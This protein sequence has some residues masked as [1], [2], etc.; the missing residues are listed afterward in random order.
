MCFQEIGG[1]AGGR[2]SCLPACIS[3]CLL[4]CLRLASTCSLACLIGGD[5]F[6]YL[7]RT[8]CTRF[9]IS[10]NEQAHTNMLQTSIVIEME[11]NGV[12]QIMVFRR[13]RRGN[14]QVVAFGQSR[15]QNLKLQGRR[16]SRSIGL[17]ICCFL[18]QPLCLG[19][20]QTS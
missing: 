19:K 15:K 1:W 14:P 3:A 13:V 18:L 10:F 6:V 12:V 2:L 17:R 9:V 5:A 4:A 16:K 11:A 7:T 8:E 20:S